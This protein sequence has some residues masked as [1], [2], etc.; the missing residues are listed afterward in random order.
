MRKVLILILLLL[1][2]TI[3][4]NALD[5][6]APTVPDSAQDLMPEEPESFSEGLWFVVKS[7]IRTLQPQ[8]AKASSVCVAVMVVCVLISVIQNFSKIFIML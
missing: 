7:A 5:F 3:Q 1:L 8:I 4:V 6:V 2:V